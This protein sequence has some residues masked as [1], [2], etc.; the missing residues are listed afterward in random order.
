MWFSHW[1]TS[2]TLK[3]KCGSP[4]MGWMIGSPSMTLSIP[5]ACTCGVPDKDVYEV[6]NMSQDP[7]KLLSDGMKLGI[8]VT[9]DRI[10]N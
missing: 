3:L 9:S 8:N 5:A 1:F 7:S 10:I 6:G 2:P 4:G